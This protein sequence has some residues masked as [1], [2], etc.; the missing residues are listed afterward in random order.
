LTDDLLD[1]EDVARLL[2]CHPNRVHRLVVRGELT[3]YGVPR[4]F[5][6]QDVLAYIERCRVKLGEMSHMYP[7]SRPSTR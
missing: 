3:A 4:R 2:A 7:A 1:V 6:R 5:K